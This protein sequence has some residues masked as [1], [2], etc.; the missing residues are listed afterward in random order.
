MWAADAE[1]SLLSARWGDP[2]IST[3]PLPSLLE[4][5]CIETREEFKRSPIHV[6]KFRVHAAVHQTI[7]Y[8]DTYDTLA[9]DLYRASITGN[10]LIIESMEPVTSDDLGFV[11]DSFG[12][13]Q[14]EAP[15]GKTEQRFGKI[16]P[17]NDMVRRELLHKMTEEHKVYSVGRFATWRNILL[18]DV[19]KDCR[20]VQRAITQGDAYARQLR[21]PR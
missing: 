20:W 3:I 7:Y 6:S 9:P 18:D 12:L 16:A 15:L 8:P 4:A 2:A 5:F 13:A 17:I 10:I 1:A 21:S 19:V 11:L 14:V